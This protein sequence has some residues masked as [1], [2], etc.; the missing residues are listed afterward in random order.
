LR[1]LYFTPEYIDF[2]LPDRDPIYIEAQSDKGRHLAALPKGHDTRS[3]ETGMITSATH[4]A[5]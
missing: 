3:H 4:V 5:T 1:S 2:G